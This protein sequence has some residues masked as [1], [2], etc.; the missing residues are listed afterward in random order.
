[1]QT[2]H[3]QPATPAPIQAVTHHQVSA[4]VAFEVIPGR[5]YLATKH[6]RLYTREPEAVLLDLTTAHPDLLAREASAHS[7]PNTASVSEVLGAFSTLIAMARAVSNRSYV[8]AAAVTSESGRSSES[9]CRT[10]A[11]NGVVAASFFMCKALQVEEL[12][13]AA[14]NGS[15]A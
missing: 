7:S 6:R 2:I 4:A 3:P 13:F 12:D 15:A 8:I 11:S 14:Q 9:I 1:M 10:L 5:V